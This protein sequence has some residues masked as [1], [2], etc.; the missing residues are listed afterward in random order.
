MEYSYLFGIVDEQY[1]PF[2]WWAEYNVYNE[3]MSFGRL[4]NMHVPT[5]IPFC[6][7]S[8]D[9]QTNDTFLEN[10]YLLG[11]FKIKLPRKLW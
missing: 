1:L 4:L 6:D 7:L 8:G 3:W 5:G 10:K 9:K 2:C 11:E